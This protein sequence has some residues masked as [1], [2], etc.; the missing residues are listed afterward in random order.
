MC[1]P[2]IVARP[3][4]LAQELR[5]AKTVLKLGFYLENAMHEGANGAGRTHTLLAIVL[6]S[7]VVVVAVL[8]FLMFNDHRDSQWRG[9][10]FDRPSVM[11]LH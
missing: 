10:A 8:G 11:P 6:S 7:L 5:R 3:R 2:A 4:T 1:F 9:G